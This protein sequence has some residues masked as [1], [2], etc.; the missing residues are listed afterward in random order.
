[1]VCSGDRRGGL[2][3]SREAASAAIGTAVAVSS[4]VG[5]GGS[6]PVKSPVA[7]LLSFQSGVQSTRSSS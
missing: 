5:A 4:T 3:L 1:M 6:S 2:P 7:A